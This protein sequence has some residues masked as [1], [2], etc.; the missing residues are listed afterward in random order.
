M[1]YN[2]RGHKESD[3]TK[4]LNSLAPEYLKFTY[5]AHIVFLMDNA[6]LEPKNHLPPAMCQ[7]LRGD[8]IAVNLKVRPKQ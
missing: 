3:M 8:Q 4:Q 1:G 6:G 7:L 5:M 2:P